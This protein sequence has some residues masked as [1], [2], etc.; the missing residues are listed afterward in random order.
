LLAEASYH[1]R[2][3]D[4]CRRREY[5]T[6]VGPRASSPNL[7]RSTIRTIRSTRKLIQRLSVNHH[8]SK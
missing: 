8:S 6:I 1:R 2:L 3:V 4:F 7:S 5:S